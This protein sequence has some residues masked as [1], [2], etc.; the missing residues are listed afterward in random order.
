MN[1]YCTRASNCVDQAG[2]LQNVEGMGIL[3]LASF[4]AR[5]IVE[6]EVELVCIQLFIMCGNFNHSAI[7]CSQTTEVS[8]KLDILHY[9]CVKIQLIGL[10]R[11]SWK[12]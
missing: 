1:I 12:S 8:R 9:L 2:Y 5:L 7:M 4:S 10:S 11:F 3:L 6:V